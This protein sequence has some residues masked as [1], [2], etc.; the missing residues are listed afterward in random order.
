M[1]L[2]KSLNERQDN[3]ERN[4]HERD[5]VRLLERDRLPTLEH[6]EMMEVEHSRE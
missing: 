2:V 6:A 4:R 1:I 3:E 5:M